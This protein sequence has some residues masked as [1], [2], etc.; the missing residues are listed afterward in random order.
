MVPQHVID[1]YLPASAQQLIVKGIP[2]K[3]LKAYAWQ[4]HKFKLW[5]EETHTTPSPVH[6]NTMIRYLDH[7]RRAPVHHRCVC[8]HHR[9]SPSTMWIWYSAVRFYHRVGDPPLPWE[10]GEN[11]TRAMKGYAE[12]MVE[13][14]WEPTR[15]PRAYDS[16]V[17]R[18]IDAL[19]LGSGRG[20][21]D[22]AV[23]LTNF[24][25]AARASDMATYRLTDVQHT[26]KGI[27]FNL[28]MSKT[29]K[30]VGKKV[31][32]RR[33]FRNTAHPAYD[34]VQAID[35]WRQWLAGQGVTSGALFRPFN[36]WDQ[37]VRGGPDQP[38]YRI[39][40]VN[41]TRVIQRAAE[42]AE[43]PHPE[44]YTCHSLRRGR[45]TQQRELGIDP[46]EIARAYGWVPGG[47]ILV[48]LE[49]A[50]GWAPTA[51]GAVGGL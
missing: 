37:L 11:L 5:C 43:L 32:Q 34:G 23:I 26:P 20:L 48:Y 27:E 31:E 29:N 14:G 50:E 21:R 3:T 45:A 19:D 49:E 16:D 33:M 42:R 22:R 10:V 46:I 12:E 28:R 13:L 36:K 9:P 8:Q 7:W 40:G 2:P 18:M 17:T 39:E 38:S 1:A 47:A 24:Y 30:S 6:Q 35:E 25:T 41:L 44:R 51:P 4:W 15:A